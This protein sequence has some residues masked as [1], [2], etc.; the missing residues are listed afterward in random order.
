MKLETWVKIFIGILAINL[1]FVIMNYFKS[2]PTAITPEDVQQLLDNQRSIIY[3][4]S[5]NQIRNEALKIMDS[6]HVL[7]GDTSNWNDLRSD[8]F[9]Q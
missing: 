4:E 2:D 1:L 3:R 7:M 5:N 6:V 9:G 8:A